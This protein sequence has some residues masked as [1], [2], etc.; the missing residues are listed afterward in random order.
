MVSACIRRY[1]AQSPALAQLSEMATRNKTCERRRCHQ[2]LGAI[3][4]QILSI[5]ST[6]T[7]TLEA[8]I[9]A[10]ASRPTASWRAWTEAL[11]M[12]AT[13]S[14]PGATSRVTSQLTAPSTILMIRPLRTF[15]ALSF[16][17]WF[18]QKVSS[19]TT[20]RY[21]TNSRRPSTDQPRLGA[22]FSSVV[23]NTQAIGRIVQDLRYRIF[24]VRRT[25]PRSL[26]RGAQR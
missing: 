15:R 10:K 4:E 25:S 16:I 19:Q 3:C 2:M 11:V 20:V 9:T 23:L 1:C 21:L 12:I 6:S 8:L 22:P 13:T 18:N 5:Y 14:T 7:M 24:S 26:R 17:L